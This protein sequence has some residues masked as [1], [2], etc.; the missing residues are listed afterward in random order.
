MRAAA[1][2]RAIAAEIESRKVELEDHSLRIATFRVKMD[3]DGMPRAVE[4]EKAAHR[5]L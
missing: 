1:I 3:K 4:Y 5:E 2:L